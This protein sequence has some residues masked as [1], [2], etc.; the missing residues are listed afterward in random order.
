MATST[1]KAVTTPET[2]IVRCDSCH[3]WGRLD[4]TIVRDR[5]EG[6][7]VFRCIYPSQ[8]LAFARQNKIGAYDCA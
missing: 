3:G 6:L 1:G 5:I 2:G 8:C 4:A 7:D